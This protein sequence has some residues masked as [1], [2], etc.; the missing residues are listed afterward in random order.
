MPPESP[1]TGPSPAHDALKFA[2]CAFGS[3][4]CALLGAVA[5][6]STPYTVTVLLSGIVVFAASGAYYLGRM[7]W[8]LMARMQ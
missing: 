1:K 8:T 4:L 7:I 2:A 5:M 3:L 6:P